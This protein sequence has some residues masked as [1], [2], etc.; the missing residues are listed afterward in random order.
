MAVDVTGFERMRREQAK[1]EAVKQE[2]TNETKTLEDMT[3]NELK[4]LA[5]EKGIQ[6]YH[7][8]KKQELIEALKEG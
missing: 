1:R 8:M 6:G 7:K 4:A 2:A 5:K 3:Y